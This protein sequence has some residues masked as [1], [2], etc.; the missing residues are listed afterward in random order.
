[1]S[2]RALETTRPFGTR[3]AKRVCFI[4][5]APHSG[6]T[7]LGMILGAH[8]DIVYGGELRKSAY[9][10]D[11][12][13]PL[14]KRVCKLCGVACPVW[15]SLRAPLDPD[16]YEVL[17]RKSEASVV[18]DSSKGTDWQREQLEV[19]SRTSTETHLVVLERDGRAVLASRLRKYPT[20]TPR[21]IIE[22]WM[23]QIEKTDA[24]AASFPGTVLRVRY[25]ALAT[26]PESEIERVTTLLGVSLEPSM[27]RFWE[28]EQH[29]LGGND[30]TQFL[31][32]RESARRRSLD[33]SLPGTTPHVSTDVLDLAADNLAYYA[34][35]PAAIVLDL[36]WQRE[37]PAEARAL[38]DS[39]A[40]EVNERFARPPA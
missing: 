15:G 38:F 10:G 11:E 18:V 31:V 29:P 12:T 34:P 8:S 36:R 27:L 35:H 16:V 2:E 1:M 22:D 30:G 9:L 40:G 25:E 5:G 19:L 26:S 20:N 32:A 6:S 28:S 7:L 37:L 24:L 17:A 23:T 39:I 21:T 4:G 3:A 14:K 13:K 33:T